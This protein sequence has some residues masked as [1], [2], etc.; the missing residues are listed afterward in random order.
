MLSR[1]FYQEEIFE[2][3]VSK[4]QQLNTVSRVSSPVTMND[5]REHMTMLFPIDKPPMTLPKLSTQPMSIAILTIGRLYIVWKDGR[6]YT[7]MYTTNG[8]LQIEGPK[9][10]DG[11]TTYYKG[12]AE[13]CSKIG[14]SYEDVLVAGKPRHRS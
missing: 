9:S 11:S 10:K 3:R 1:S 12:F 7:V 2:P 14:A 5:V 13:W 8:L 6:R 4:A